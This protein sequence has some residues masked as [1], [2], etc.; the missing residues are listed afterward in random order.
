MIKHLI[1][2]Q[3]GADFSLWLKSGNVK[4]CFECAHL[5]ISAPVSMAASLSR[6]ASFTLAHGWIIHGGV[7]VWPEADAVAHLLCS[8]SSSSN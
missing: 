2:R 1:P 6:S 7:P 8:S 5:S 4:W 3:G